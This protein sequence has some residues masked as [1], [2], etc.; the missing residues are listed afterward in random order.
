MQQT[1]DSKVQQARKKKL[2]KQGTPKREKEYSVKFDF[3][4]PGPIGIP[5]IQIK[6]AT[7]GYAKDKLLFEQVLVIRFVYQF[8]LF[9]NSN[10]W[11]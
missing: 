1:K 9:D 2:D 10:S 5:I 6:D 8:S 7:F 4:S 3:P 11:T